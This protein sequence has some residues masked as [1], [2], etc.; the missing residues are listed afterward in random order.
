VASNPN[1]VVLDGDGAEVAGLQFWGIGDPRYTPDKSEPVGGQSEQERASA[2]APVVADRLERG[3][4]PAVDV[5]LVHDARMAEDLGGRVPLVLAGH[6]HK[7]RSDTIDP[8]AEDED[9]GEDDG[10]DGEGT[11]STTTEATTTTSGGEEPDDTL[12]LVEGSTG[13]GG[14]RALQGGEPL[15]LTASVLYFDPDTHRLLAY[16][17]IRVAGLGGTGATIERHIVGQTPL[18]QETGAVAP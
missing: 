4:P 13:G 15:P 12:L 18:V 6:G 17:R 7:P 8:P 10:E 11:G 16:D 14:L 3:E 9:G 1:A 5:A 2:F